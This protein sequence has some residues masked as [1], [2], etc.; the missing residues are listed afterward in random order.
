VIEGACEPIYE[1][2]EEYVIPVDGSGNGGEV[3]D[4]ARWG[5]SDQ[6]WGE[7]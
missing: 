4:K 1:D 7:E 5:G 2:E 3:G 6:K